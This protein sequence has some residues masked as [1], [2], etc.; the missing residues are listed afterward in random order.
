MFPQLLSGLLAQ[1]EAHEAVQAF[2]NVNL[3]QQLAGQLQVV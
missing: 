1:V 3:G 2:M